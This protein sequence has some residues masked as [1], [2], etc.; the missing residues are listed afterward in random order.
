[1]YIDKSC[2][3]GKSPIRNLLGQFHA[4]VIDFLR[5]KPQL[6]LSFPTLLGLKVR[7]DLQS[8]AKHFL[9]CFQFIAV[10]IFKPLNT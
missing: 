8:T 5:S 3:N 2:S 7:S 10:Q 1:M 4:K 9:L 6:I